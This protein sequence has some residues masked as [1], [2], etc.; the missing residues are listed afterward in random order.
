[1]TNYLPAVGSDNSWAHT[2]ALKNML[3]CLIIL[4]KANIFWREWIEVGGRAEN[5][6]QCA[7]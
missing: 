5:Q 4:H 6:Q 7:K 1:M 2:E 3:E